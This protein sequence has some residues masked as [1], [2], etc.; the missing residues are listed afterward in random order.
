MTIL[1]A[2]A[3]MLVVAQEKAEEIMALEP[4]KLIE[5]LKDPEAS[6]FA[7]AKA[8]QRLAVTGGRQRRDTLAT[9][10][11]PETSQSRARASLSRDLSVINRLLGSRWLTAD[12]GGM[13][14]RTSRRQFAIPD[15]ICLTSSGMMHVGGRSDSHGVLMMANSSLLS[16]VISSV[17][18]RGA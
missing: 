5:I 1:L 13:T 10:L 18:L 6:L 9:L 16:A 15:E 14:S 4:A 11:W 3:P 17:L 7:K 2:V 12:P 8:C